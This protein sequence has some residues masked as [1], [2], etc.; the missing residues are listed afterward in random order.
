MY[1]TDSNNSLENCLLIEIRMLEADSNAVDK[2][3]RGGRKA[4]KYGMGIAHSKEKIS[5]RYQEFQA[6]PAVQQRQRLIYLCRS[7]DAGIHNQLMLLID[8]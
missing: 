7:T 1:R 6:S 3:C 4:D 5:L 8:P 2:I